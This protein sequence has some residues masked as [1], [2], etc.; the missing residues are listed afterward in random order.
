MIR[1][2]LLLIM[3]IRIYHYGK[4]QEKALHHLIQTY[5]QKSSKFLQCKIIALK[6]SKRERQGVVE[7]GRAFL[8]KLQPSDFVV[9][10]DNHGKLLSSEALATFIQK[11][12]NHSAQDLVFVIGGSYGFSDEVYDRAQ[13]KLS[14]SPMT[15]T[16]D[17]ALFLFSEQLY[18]A[19]AILNHLPYH[20]A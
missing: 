8:A 18:R 3:K 10:L 6:D 14:L 9:A 19:F 20:H 17:M 12:M 4:V 13:M 11:R 1:L 2:I 15:F 5:V 7:E 16:H